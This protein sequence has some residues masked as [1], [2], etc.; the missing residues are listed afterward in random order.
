MEEEKQDHVKG[1]SSP[2]WSYYKPRSRSV[3]SASASGLDTPPLSRKGSPTEEDYQDSRGLIRITRTLA[4]ML[5]KGLRA[6]NQTEKEE[7]LEVMNKKISKKM[8]ALNSRKD[9]QRIKD[10]YQALQSRMDMLV[11]TLEQEKRDR[12]A[13]EFRSRLKHP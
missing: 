1:D 6:K 8:V 2:D 13:A 3:D 9:H 4:Q 7:A 12:D 11:E 10:E 5:D